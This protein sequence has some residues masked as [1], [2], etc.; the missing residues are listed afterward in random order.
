MKEVVRRIVGAIVGAAALVTL[1]CQPP[2]VIHGQVPAPRFGN[3]MTTAVRAVDVPFYGEPSL[4]DWND[5]L[6]IYLQ[7]AESRLCG[8]A[9]LVHARDGKRVKARLFVFNYVHGQGPSGRGDYLVDV[10]EDRLESARQ[11]LLTMYWEPYLVNGKRYTAWLV[12]MGGPGGE[13][14]RCTEEH[15]GGMYKPLGIVRGGPRSGPPGQSAPEASPEEP[16]P[17]QSGKCRALKKHVSDVLTAEVALHTSAMMT[18]SPAERDAYVADHGPLALVTRK[19]IE[20][21]PGKQKVRAMKLLHPLMSD[22]VR[23]SIMKCNELD[24]AVLDCEMGA[25][26]FAAVKAC[27]K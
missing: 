5:G 17:P 13:F 3:V 25:K 6:V 11:G 23:T 2:P 7:G 22:F 21:P 10:P 18:M 27:S 16:A 14:P 24:E 26:D 19:M 8:D 15:S 12:A 20:A 9:I 1:G 4:R